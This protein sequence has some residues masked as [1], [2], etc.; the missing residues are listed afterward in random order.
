M[1]YVDLLGVNEDAIWNQEMEI[2]FA[3]GARLFVGLD[4]VTF[5]VAHLHGMSGRTVGGWR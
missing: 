3:T 5:R 1:R 4:K 2:E